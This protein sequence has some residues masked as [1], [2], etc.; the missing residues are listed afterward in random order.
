[1]IK[2]VV[3]PDSNPEPLLTLRFSTGKKLGPRL[4]TGAPA[5]KRES[6]RKHHLR[7]FSGWVT[8]DR[9]VDLIL[10]FIFFVAWVRGVILWCSFVGKGSLL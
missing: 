9:E 4:V 1:M 6:L 3:L 2:S 8:P 5:G 10:I 7:H